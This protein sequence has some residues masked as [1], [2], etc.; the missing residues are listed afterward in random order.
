MLQYGFDK[1]ASL[2]EIIVRSS[3]DDITRR[4]LLSLLPDAS[5]DDEIIC[6]MSDYLTR[7]ESCKSHGQP[8]SWFLPTRY[9]QFATMPNAHLDGFK[10]ASQYRKHYM[11]DLHRCHQIFVPMHDGGHHWF[12]VLVKIKDKQAEI[13]DPLPD[14]RRT[15]DREIQVN[16]ILHSLDAILHGVVDAT[17]SVAWSFLSF[18][19]TYGEGV[20]R[21]P[22]GFDCGVYVIKFMDTPGI[23]TNK[24]MTHRMFGRNLRYNL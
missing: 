24:S 22:N 11:Y 17:Y 15:R 23:I 1:S 4:G 18:V 12:M 7:R 2:D 9:A 8:I 21:Q 3:H 10:A 13:W 19:V 20:P 6:M 16:S 14:A 5:L